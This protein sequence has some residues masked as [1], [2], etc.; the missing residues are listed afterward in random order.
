MCILEGSGDGGATWSGYGT[1]AAGSSF[2]STFNTVPGLIRARVYRTGNIEGST[3]S[4]TIAQTAY[5]APGDSLAVTGS[6]STFWEAGPIT[7]TPTG[8]AW[9][10]PVTYPK[11][12]WGQ[13]LRNTEAFVNRYRLKVDYETGEDYEE[14]FA[15]Q[16]GEERTLSVINAINFTPTVEV[17]RVLPDG[18]GVVWVPS[19][20][21]NSVTSTTE[22]SPFTAVNSGS[23]ATGN[24]WS[25]TTAPTQFGTQTPIAPTASPRDD[26]SAASSDAL[27]RLIDS[28]ADKRHAELKS[29][30]I[31]ADNAEAKR[32]TVALQ[33]QVMGL[34][35][36][37]ATVASLGTGASGA[38]TAGVGAG[39]SFDPGSV[40][41]TS[42]GSALG[43][44]EPTL[45]AI[46]GSP[47]LTLALPFSQLSGELEDAEID[48][49]SEHLS[50]AVELARAFFLVLV[51]VS[52]FF[53]SFK[54]IG[55]AGNV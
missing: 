44:F 34:D 36:V 23:T 5:H 24:I 51:T 46:S 48:L 11:H 45:S 27:Q 37:A 54:I 22:S 7:L 40:S 39:A 25:N 16:P 55:R 28:N 30:L 18:L 20:G 43:G 14:I 8:T 53:T 9:A 47:D 3:F 10:P 42:F 21:L 1:G 17:E 32:D 6:Q 38:T 2:V 29:L 49:G 50:E 13:T 33:A 4:S 15:L 31:A 52:F 35:R 19:T 41:G 26:T 12:A